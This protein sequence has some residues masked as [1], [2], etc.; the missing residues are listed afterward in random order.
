[1]RTVLTIA[2][3]TASV[4]ASAATPHASARMDGESFGV[5]FSGSEYRPAAA[6]IQA[7]PA[8]AASANGGR[9]G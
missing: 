2:V 4:I 1:M 3:D 9:N 7:S 6:M 5:Q 8:P